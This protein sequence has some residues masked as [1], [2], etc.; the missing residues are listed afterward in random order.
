MAT[1]IRVSGR[2]LLPYVKLGYETVDV[3]LSRADGRYS[4]ST[5]V[6]IQ[7]DASYMAELAWWTGVGYFI[8]VDVPTALWTAVD[9]AVP[10]QVLVGKKYTAVAETLDLEISQQSTNKMQGSARVTLKVEQT[11]G[12]EVGGDPDYLHPIRD[13][14]TELVTGEEELFVAGNW[15]G[16][17][18]V[19]MQQASPLPATILCLTANVN[20]SGS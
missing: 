17:A 12:L 4:V 14:D 7:R 10:M 6:A 9:G 1:T 5:G 11:V 8:E 16:G 19:V 15:E 13:V 2:S 3:V 20:V 18:S